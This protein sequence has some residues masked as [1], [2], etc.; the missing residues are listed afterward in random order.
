MFLH[1]IALFFDQLASTDHDVTTCLV[2][3]ENLSL[4][5]ATDEVSDI[6]GASDI[7]LTCRQENID[8]YVEEQPSLDFANNI[9]RDNIALRVI[10]DYSFPA[11]DA[12]CFAFRKTYEAAV[13][14]KVV[15]QHF[16]FFASLRFFF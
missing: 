8:T 10:A 11:A 4:N 1:F 15:K 13:V 9:A 16:D 7:N 3:F 14:F 5:S 12:S 6:S 2:N